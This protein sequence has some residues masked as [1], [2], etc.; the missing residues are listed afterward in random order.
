MISR[1][2]ESYPSDEP[3]GA[4]AVKGKDRKQSREPKAKSQKV[5]SQYSGGL[6]GRSSSFKRNWAGGWCDAC[7]GRKK[8]PGTPYVI[9]RFDHNGH[10]VKE[11]STD[12]GGYQT[13]NGGHQ[14]VAVISVDLEDL[15]IA[16]PREPTWPE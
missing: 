1:S 11:K 15:M 16:S 13:G 2:R 9:V 12:S 8:E 5:K 4:E 14:S 7:R 6:L 3:K 10:E